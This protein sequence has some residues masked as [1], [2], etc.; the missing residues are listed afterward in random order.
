M[1]PSWSPYSQCQ[2]FSGFLVIWF[3]SPGLLWKT[4]S[5]IFPSDLICC[6]R[7]VGCQLQPA[8]LLEILSL[9]LYLIFLDLTVQL[10]LLCLY[11]H[12]L[13]LF[14]YKYHSQ[15]PSKCTYITTEAFSPFSLSDRICYYSWDLSSYFYQVFF[16][17]GLLSFLPSA[18]HF[19]L[20]D[21]QALQQTQQMYTW[22]PLLPHVACCSLD[23]GQCHGA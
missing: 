23:C 20:D 10:F 19:H 8:H 4:K 3:L 12:L 14:S 22:T 6:D 18:R 2:L 11:L 13:L 15:I 9:W 16:C 17:C 7:F 1:V 21:P 5:S